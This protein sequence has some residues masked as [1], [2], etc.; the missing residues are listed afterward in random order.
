MLRFFFIWLFISAI[1]RLLNQESKTI[2]ELGQSDSGNTQQGVNRRKWDA[3]AST[4]LVV[5]GTTL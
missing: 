1:G 3:C 4:L 5:L 2:K